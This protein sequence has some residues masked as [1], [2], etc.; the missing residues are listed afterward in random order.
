MSKASLGI[1]AD[2][3]RDMFAHIQRLP[4]SFHDRWPS[5]QLLSRMTSDLSTLRRFTGFGFVFLIANSGTTLVVLALL[6]HIH[7]WLGCS[8]RSR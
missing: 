3:R 4:V 1:E 2:L 5:G 8:S 7:L 6:I